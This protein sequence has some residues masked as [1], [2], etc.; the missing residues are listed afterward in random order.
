MLRSTFI[1][2]TPSL[3]PGAFWLLKTSKAC[4]ES[5]QYFCCRQ[6]QFTKLPFSNLILTKICYGVCLFCLFVCFI[7]QSN[8]T[9]FKNKT[10]ISTTDV[11]GY[12]NI[13]SINM[14]LVGQQKWNNTE[15]KINLYTVKNEVDYLWL[16]HTDILYFILHFQLLYIEALWVK[17]ICYTNLM[18]HC[19]F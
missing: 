6:Q 2:L 3:V 4:F 16:L 15:A 13:I 7:F 12:M 18:Q 10:V 17:D 9:S 1:S 11:V 14:F 5:F 19:T 8:S